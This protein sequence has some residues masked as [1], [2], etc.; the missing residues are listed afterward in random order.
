MLNVK[1]IHVFAIFEE[2]EKS[3]EFFFV[4]IDIIN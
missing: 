1:K 2:R 4:V 3:A